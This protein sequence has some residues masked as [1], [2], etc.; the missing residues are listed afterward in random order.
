LRN[1]GHISEKEIKLLI[2]LCRI[3]PVKHK[4]IGGVDSNIVDL[5]A[6]NGV[7]GWLYL[8][9]K[10]GYLDW[11]DEHSL[12]QL[13]TYYIRN[14][15]LFQKYIDVYKRIQVT[16]KKHNISVLALKGFA[17]GLSIYD[18]AG[19]RPMSDIDILVPEGKGSDALRILLDD[20]FKVVTIPRSKLHEKVNGHM[21]A[22]SFNGVMVEVH[23][24]LYTLGSRY[25]L[26]G[27]DLF[28]DRR[29]VKTKDIEFFRLNDILMGYHL[30]TH[31]LTTMNMG[32]LRLSWLLDI[33]LLLNKQK[34]KEGF[35]NTVIR[36]NPKIKK[37]ILKIIGM[38]SLLWT[39]GE[40][41]VKVDEEKVL[42]EINNLL[43]SRDMKKKHRIINA[44]EIINTPGLLNKILLLRYELFPD[45][46]Y[47]RYRYGAQGSLMRLYLKRLLRF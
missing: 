20:G 36:I 15:L 13:K 33:A 8:K 14:F 22:V 9:V 6:Q 34:D 30:I 5:A 43:K 28:K 26:S 21:R 7:A 4:T 10:N 42:I 37:D 11:G 16:L 19:V 2:D 39:A 3:A 44:Y 23:Q 17:L 32:G 31:T 38:A 29:L 27:M 25:N 12:N 24:R 45:K 35:I 46:E 47:M 1:T 41:S 18:D 40:R